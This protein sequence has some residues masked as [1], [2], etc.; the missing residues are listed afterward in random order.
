MSIISANVRK[1]RKK[2]KEMKGKNQNKGNMKGNERKKE[3]SG[4]KIK[5]K[6]VSLHLA[7]AARR[8]ILTW[9]LSGR[10]EY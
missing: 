2:R 5:G 10:R 6:E 8:K 9:P 7:R 3:G 4:T 1:I